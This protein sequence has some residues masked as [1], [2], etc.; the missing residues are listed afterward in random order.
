MNGLIEQL[1]KF[2]TPELE[3]ELKRRKTMNALSVTNKVFEV[4]CNYYGTTEKAVMY[5][6]EKGF[7]RGVGPVRNAKRAL[8]YIFYLHYDYTAAKTGLIMKKNHSTCLVSANKVRDEMQVNPRY[9]KEINF[10]IK[11][12][13]Q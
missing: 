10:L 13:K 6:G 9:R 3:Q 1:E 2:S 12:I 11:L 7:A 4:V 5:K 8:M